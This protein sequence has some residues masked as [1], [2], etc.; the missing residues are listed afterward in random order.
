MTSQR[1]TL[2]PPSRSLALFSHSLSLPGLRAYSCYSLRFPPPKKSAFELSPA[3]SVCTFLSNFI[4]SFLI[5][6][7][8]PPTPPGMMA[9]RFLVSQTR[10][11]THA[12]FASHH[13]PP[14]PHSYNP[15][16][17]FDASRLAGHFLNGPACCLFWLS[18]LAGMLVTPD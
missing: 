13:P 15:K 2:S 5:G 11:A 1:L 14:T 18:C 7:P 10:S 12:N 16:L 9:L 4:L 3:L 17:K 6:L 8:F